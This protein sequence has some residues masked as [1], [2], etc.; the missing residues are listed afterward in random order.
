MSA[1]AGGATH[2][3]RPSFGN[4]LLEVH[5]YAYLPQVSPTAVLTAGTFVPLVEVGLLTPLRCPSAPSD[6]CPGPVLSTLMGTV[7][8]VE[9][10]SGVAPGLRNVEHAHM[11][12]GLHGRRWRTG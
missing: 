1:A 7:H 10:A 12:C 2:L 3:A 11:W 6:T 5:Y 8:Q 9:A 4:F